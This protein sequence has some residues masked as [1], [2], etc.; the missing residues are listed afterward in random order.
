MQPD[1]HIQREISRL[2]L[3]Q[4][5]ALIREFLPDIYLPVRG[6]HKSNLVEA[7]FKT[8]SPSM[9]RALYS[10]AVQWYISPDEKVQSSRKTRKRKSTEDNIE[11]EVEKKRRIQCDKKDNVKDSRAAPVS[12]SVTFS[13]FFHNIQCPLQGLNSVIAH[14]R[15][16][17][18]P[19][20]EKAPSG[21]STPFP[22]SLR[23]SITS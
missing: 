5:Q 18:F 3:S 19:Y 4:L 6:R 7:L 2:T 23:G 22:Y 17:K 9:L 14:V 13:F 16:G 12:P 1:D 11:S 20:H 10:A 15:T 21:L 8:V